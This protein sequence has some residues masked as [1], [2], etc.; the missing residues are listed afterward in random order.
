MNFQAVPVSVTSRKGDEHYTTQSDVKIGVY[1]DRV[2]QIGCPE[3][4]NVRASSSRN[5]DS[6]LWHGHEVNLEFVG[7]LDIIMKNYPQTFEHSTAKSERF[8]TMMLNMLCT[9]VTEFLRTSMA[10][11]NVDIISKYRDLF[12]DLQRWGFQLVWLLSHLNNIE[13]L[14]VSPHELHTTDSCVDDAKSKLQELQAYCLEKI[15]EI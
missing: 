15:T 4:S 1:A 2:R 5:S 12:A 7:L 3:I 9:S 11:F 13:Q 8:H 14:L 6:G 10:D